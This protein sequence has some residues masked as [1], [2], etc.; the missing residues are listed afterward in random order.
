MT[1]EAE[2]CDLTVLIP[3]YDE[4]ENVGP[5]TDELRAVLDGLGKSY[6]A[7]FVDDGSTDG[8]HKAL[9]DIQ[10]RWPQVRLIKLKQNR[11]KTTALVAG[12]RR[13]RGDVIVIMDGD[14]QNDPHDIP[15]LLE[16]IPPCDLVCGVRVKRHDTW[17]R[18]VQ[19]RIANRVRD[20]VIQDRIRDSGS[21]LQAFRRAALEGQTF[22][23]GLHRFLPA[24]FL[25]EGFMVAQVP[26][27]HRPR[28]HGKAKYNLLNR[29]VRAFDDMMAVRWLR[30]RRIHYEV[31]EER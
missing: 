20:W 17:F 8:T 7:L 26:V 15:K 31:E 14:L 27:N 4:E 21:G 23:D 5:L 22:F 25:L 30:S 11:G 12:W 10:A 13:A 6:E 28:M 24:M 16:Q 3:V 9:C 1:P 29:V 19:S 2:T 18:R